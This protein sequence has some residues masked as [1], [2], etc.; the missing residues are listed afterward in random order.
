MRVFVYALSVVAAAGIVYWVSNNGTDSKAAPE[1]D[2]V[3]TSPAD[4]PAIAPVDESELQLVSVH[5]P[6]M[7]CPF[8][9]YPAVK[10]T[11][12]GTAGVQGVELAEQKEEGVID[13]PVVIIKAAPGFDVQKAMESLA[14]TGFSDSSVV[15]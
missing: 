11:L 3:A 9:C 2:S 8:A 12:E 4:A 5:V 10:K 7:H 13:N 14:A 1:A 15:Q 6:K